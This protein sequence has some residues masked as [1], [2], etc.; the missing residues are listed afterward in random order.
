MRPGGGDA[1]PG[2]PDRPRRRF[3]RR[4]RSIY[5]GCHGAV[6]ASLDFADGPVVYRLV[7]FAPPQA[8]SPCAWVG[9]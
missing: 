1:A 2:P 7:Q 4:A 6:A 3:K 8:M 5:G 9:A